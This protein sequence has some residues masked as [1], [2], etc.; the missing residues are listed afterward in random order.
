MASV[1]RAFELSGLDVLL[2]VYANL[3]AA[4]DAGPVSDDA[5]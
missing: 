4:L 1:P 5:V 3:A 2:P